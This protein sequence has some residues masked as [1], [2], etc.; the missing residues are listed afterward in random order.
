[1]FCVVDAWIQVH[2]CSVS[3]EHKGSYLDFQFQFLF[4]LYLFSCARINFLKLGSRLKAGL[5][6]HTLTTERA[7]IMHLNK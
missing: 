6:L 7:L 5:S 4:N 2:A 1:M 3:A